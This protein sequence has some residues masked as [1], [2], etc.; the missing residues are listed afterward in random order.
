MKDDNFQ[1]SNVPNPVNNKIQDITDQKLLKGDIVQCSN[2]SNPVN[3]ELQEVIKPNVEVKIE[4]LELDEEFHDA[5]FSEEVEDN[6]KT[7]SKETNVIIKEESISKNIK[8][9][10]HIDNYTIC[11]YFNKDCYPG[12]NLRKNNIAMLPSSSSWT[13]SCV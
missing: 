9:S 2:T 13:W 12:S 6:T 3:T 4:P 7:E 10:F 8:H 1:C 11:I 5:L